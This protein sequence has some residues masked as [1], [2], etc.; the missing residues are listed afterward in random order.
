[1]KE[2]ILK[3]P[4][5]KYRFFMNLVKNLGFV[6]IEKEEEGDSKEEI[7]RSIRSGLEDMQRHNEGKLKTTPTKDFLN[8]L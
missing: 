4:D 3:V 6:K 1:M 5:K 7:V 2:V 8:E